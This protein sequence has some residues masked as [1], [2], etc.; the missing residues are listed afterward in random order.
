MLL[1]DFYT[2]YNL[3]QSLSCAGIPNAI[4]KIISEY[5]T[6]GYEDAK[7]KAFMI[8]RRL[9]IIMGFTI[10]IIL[11]VFAPVISKAILGDLQGGNT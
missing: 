6:L 1:G 8:G 2:I 10:F 5:Q 4:S 7:E 3:F 11:F 9:A